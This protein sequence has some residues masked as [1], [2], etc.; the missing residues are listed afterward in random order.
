M[1]ILSES[2]AA[3]YLRIGERE[4]RRLVAGRQIPFIE[5]P[6]GQVRFDSDD[7]AEWCRG[8]RRAPFAADL[9]PSDRM[10]RDIQT[11]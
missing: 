3:S 1:T 6:D 5:L 11:R 9:V 4:L 8:R 2:G 7:L 10:V